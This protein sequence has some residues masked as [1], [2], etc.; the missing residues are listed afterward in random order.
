M[1]SLILFLLPVTRFHLT[2]L[3]H[4]ALTTH[5]ASLRPRSCFSKGSRFCSVSRDERIVRLQVGCCMLAA[6]IELSSS[7]TGETLYSNQTYLVD[8]H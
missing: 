8:I 3:S 7:S 4:I 1:F 2:L 6:P 5:Y